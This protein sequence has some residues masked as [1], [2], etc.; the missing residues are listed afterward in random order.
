[1]SNIC[2]IRWLAKSSQTVLLQNSGIHI[3][4]SDL[5]HQADSDYLI[6]D[7]MKLLGS[8]PEHN[9]MFVRLCR[10]CGC[11]FAEEAAA[12]EEING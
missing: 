12:K 3:L 10:L 11:L 1:M 2:L 6:G 9:D 8:T 5:R 4:N 7:A